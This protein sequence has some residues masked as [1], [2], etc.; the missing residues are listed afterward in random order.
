M[1][2]VITMNTMKVVKWV[3]CA[4][5]QN[6]IKGAA[7]NGAEAFRYHFAVKLANRIALL[8]KID[9]YSVLSVTQHNSETFGVFP[10]KGNE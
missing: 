6:T 7:R 10:T 2:P 3:V 1:E 5:I 8:G 9:G 4:H